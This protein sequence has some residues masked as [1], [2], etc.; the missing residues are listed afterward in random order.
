MTVASQA[1]T[2]TRSWTGVES[3]IASGLAAADAV[4]VGVIYDGPAGRFALTPGVHFSPRLQGGGGA[5][6]LVDLYPLAM[7]PGPAT[8]LLRRR[9]PALQLADFDTGAFD[10][11]VL[12]RALDAGALRDAELREG[13]DR[14]VQVPTGEVGLTLPPVATRAGKVQGFDGNGDPV[15][16]VVPGSVGSVASTGISDSTVSGRAL[17][18]AS[19]VSAQ[20]SLLGF[21]VD[22]DTLAAAQAATISGNLV[23]TKG[24]RAVNDNGGALYARVGSA[25]AHA[26][27]F[28]DAS[29]AWF[30]LQGVQVTPEQFDAVGDYDRVAKTGTDNVT[31][32]QSAL[33]YLTVRGGG[34]LALR[35]GARYRI[36]DEIYVGSNT[37]VWTD[38]HLRAS[39]NRHLIAT[40]GNLYRGFVAVRDPAGAAIRQNVICA[41][42][43]IWHAAQ[44]TAQ[45]TA[46]AGQTTFAYDTT[47]VTNAFD[48]V[49]YKNGSEV[50]PNGPDFTYTST[51]VTLVT[52][53]TG[54]DM[55]RIGR[56]R[57]GVRACG[58]YAEG[59]A[60]SL[61]SDITIRNIRVEGNLSLY[62]GVML[63][64]CQDCIV[65]H[66]RVRTV[67]NRGLYAYG[68]GINERWIDCHVNGQAG[69]ELGVFSGQRVTDYAIDNNPFTATQQ[70][71]VTWESCTVS[72]C[73]RGFSHGGFAVGCSLIDFK[74]RYVTTYG[75]LL[76]GEGALSG[77]RFQVR[78]ADLA[79]C[80]DYAV[81][82]L[83]SHVGLREITAVGCFG[84]IYARNPGAD[85]GEAHLQIEG[86]QN[87]DNAATG[88]ALTILNYT[89]ASLGAI[90]IASA[91]GDGVI[92]DASDYIIGGPV[93]VVTSAGTGLQLR[94]GADRNHIEVMASGCATGVVIFGGCSSNTIIGQSIANTTNL[95]DGG[96]ASD[97]A[98]LRIT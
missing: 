59:T 36:D 60:A 95:S 9:T 26:G 57:A 1:V 90:Q 27:K 62:I 79:Q 37:A 93:N 32:L 89:R 85:A 41:D 34:V 65:E 29:G 76:Q 23:R 16:L 20:Q 53:A 3:V 7:P 66:C 45:F 96:T 49:I 13:L 2:A 40:T 43:D 98:R 78:G 80:D 5:A 55:I 39:F 69:T 67:K 21:A 88:S 12:E 58:V 94:N 92:L 4:D 56:T 87:R 19:S 22:F 75:I 51:T 42:F 48:L 6:G 61:S 24:R 84:G 35:A 46:T 54:G 18:T 74:A 91:L 38:G 73:G 97:V 11:D 81:Y 44:T 86:F 63:Y 28:Q 8:L 50:S 64:N 14:S 77:D 83:V 15:A 10:P 68:W 17:L 30:E 31:A 52:P 70:D 72:Q 47:G 71:A 25:P 82:C 33:D